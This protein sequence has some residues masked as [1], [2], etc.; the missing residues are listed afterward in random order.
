MV[1]AFTSI[2]VHRLGEEQ[3][4]NDYCR[5]RMSIDFKMKCNTIFRRKVYITER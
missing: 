2:V 5:S 1:L 4:H 3:R